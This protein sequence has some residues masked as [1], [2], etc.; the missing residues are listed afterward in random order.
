MVPEVSI[1]MFHLTN[2]YTLCDLVKKV[3]LLYSIILYFYIALII[4]KKI[5]Y[6]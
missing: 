3:Y 6:I 5:P 2:F 4:R 1:I